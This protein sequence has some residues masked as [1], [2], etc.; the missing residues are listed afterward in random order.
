MKT[1]AQAIKNGDIKD[2]SRKKEVIWFKPV[3]NSEAK[4]MRP[5]KTHKDHNITKCWG[6]RFVNQQARANAQKENGKK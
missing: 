2:H 4:V 1:R 6:N 3:R 5:G